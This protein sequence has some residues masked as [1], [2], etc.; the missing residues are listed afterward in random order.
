[1][2][3]TRIGLVVHPTRAVEHPLQA[4]EEWASANSVE[5]VQVAA[6][7]QQQPVA[8]PGDPADCDLLVSIGGDGTTLAALRTGSGV[9]RPMLGVAC[10][11]LGVLTSV[12]PDQVLSALDRFSTGDWVPLELPALLISVEQNEKSFALNDIAVVRAGPG[13]VLVASHVDGVLF[14]RIAGDGCIVSTPVGS[15]AY[16]LAA[17]GPLLY[18]EAQAF[19]FTPLTIHGGSCP[20][21]VLGPESRLEL[22]FD[23]RHGGARL[24]IDGQVV[25]DV[26]EALQ[27][28]FSPAAATV[29]TFPDQEPLLSR[30][31]RVE[32]V[33]DSPRILA[34]RGYQPE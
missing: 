24:E 4:L 25:G 23:T 14:A 2:S 31:R 15:S 22:E 8:E 5:V 6:P 11:S 7:C 30:L 12:P 10:G 33:T 21:L 32:I 28:T 1:M 17:G 16:G 13:Q 26:P 29:V 20:P 34:E 9:G 18:L 3:V 19:V 27:I